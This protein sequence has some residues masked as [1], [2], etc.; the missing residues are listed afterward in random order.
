MCIIVD[1]NRLGVFLQDDVHEDSEPVR[2]WIDRGWGVVVYSTDATFAGELRGRRARERLADYRRAGKAKAFSGEE[3]ANDERDLQRG[4]LLR[5]NGSHIIALARASG[6]RLLY[7]GDSDLMDD[8]RNKALI[9]S[10]RGRIYSGA[11]NENLL[12]RSVC[13][14]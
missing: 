11:R 4:G 7:T 13:R 8:F 12:T 5:S 2:Q 9:D 1:A 3:F 14:M 10:P 6:A